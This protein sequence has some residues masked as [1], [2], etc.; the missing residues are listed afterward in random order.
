MWQ[1]AIRWEQ[2]GLFLLRS[3]AQEQVHSCF[4]VIA[5][6]LFREQ[7]FLRRAV[8]RIDAVMSACAGDPAGAPS[9]SVRDQVVVLINDLSRQSATALEEI[10]RMGSALDAIM[11]AAGV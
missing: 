11:T 7:E 2:A 10:H 4:R 3:G 6:Y 9:A 1:L 8:A 5:D